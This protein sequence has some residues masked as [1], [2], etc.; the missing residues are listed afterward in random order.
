VPGRSIA[1]ALPEL[2]FNYG[3]LQAR[4]LSKRIAWQIADYGGLRT[5][6]DT[7]LILKY[8]DD[9]WRAWTKTNPSKAAQTSKEEWRPISAWG[10]SMHNYGAA[11]DVEIVTAPAGMSKLAAL[12][13]VLDDGVALGMASGRDFGRADPPH[14]ELRF[15]GTVPGPTALVAA[16]A[17]WQRLNGTDFFRR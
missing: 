12:N 8:R 5:R 9:D 6:A 4:A 7:S 2:V 13:M 11:F 10:F 15:A 14:L 16:K 3:E 1:G 17:E